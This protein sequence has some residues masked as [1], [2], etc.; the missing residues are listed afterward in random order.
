MGDR[1]SITALTMALVATM[2]PISPPPLAPMGLWRL[3]VT[4]RSSSKV[5]NSSAMGMA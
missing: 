2:D 4:V 3:G 5:G 1:A